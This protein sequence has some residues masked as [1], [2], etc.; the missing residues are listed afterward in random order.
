MEEGYSL[1]EPELSTKVRATVARAKSTQQF[2]LDEYVDDGH[3][4]HNMQNIGR[5][6]G[7]KYFRKRTVIYQ[8]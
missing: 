8:S 4:W 3:F 1:I 2:L 5:E 7:N 6:D